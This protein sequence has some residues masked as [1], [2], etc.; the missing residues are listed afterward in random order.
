MNYLNNGCISVFKIVV[1]CQ[2]DIAVCLIKYLY[3]L[4]NPNPNPTYWYH[5]FMTYGLCIDDN[6]LLQLYDGTGGQ[7]KLLAIHPCE[8]DIKRW[9]GGDFIAMDTIAVWS[10]VVICGLI[11]SN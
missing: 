1:G 9:E 8:K 2:N 10:K 6:V 4:P 3:I 7:M 5:S 11:T